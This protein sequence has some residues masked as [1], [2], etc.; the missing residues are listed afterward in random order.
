MPFYII[1]E[2]GKGYIKIG[3]GYAYDRMREFSTGNPHNMEL[4]KQLPGGYREEH[5]LHKVFY[6]ERLDPSHEWFFPSEELLKAA[7]LE[8]KELVNLINNAEK[9]IAS[10]PYDWDRMC[11]KFD[12]ESDED[13]ERRQEKYAAY[14]AA[15]YLW[16]Y[17]E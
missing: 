12:G 16:K 15:P 2:D 13:V 17:G 4:L 11:V 14:R 6:R 1:Q 8:D 10:H 5:I 7:S 9:I 3:K